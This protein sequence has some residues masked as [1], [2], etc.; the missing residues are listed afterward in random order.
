VRWQE[1]EN[2]KLLRYRTR[3]LK[4]HKVVRQQIRGEVARRRN[5]EC[6]VAVIVQDTLTIVTSVKL[7]DMTVNENLLNP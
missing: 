5:V 1:E 6:Y 2:V 4:Y 7:G 3:T